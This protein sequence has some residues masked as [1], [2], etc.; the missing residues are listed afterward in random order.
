MT[1]EFLACALTESAQVYMHVRIL[2][3]SMILHVFP[4]MRCLGSESSDS[5][6]LFIKPL[7][8][9]FSLYAF[10]SQKE[11]KVISWLQKHI[12]IQEKELNERAKCYH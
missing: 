12:K 7:W 11:P 4:S 3:S 1:H 9:G 8:S 2:S 10:K 6:L 5:F